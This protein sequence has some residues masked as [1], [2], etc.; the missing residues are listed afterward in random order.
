[1]ID[2]GALKVSTMV[3]PD[4]PPHERAAFVLDRLSSMAGEKLSYSLPAYLASRNA[5]FADYA[6]AYRL[7]RLP[8]ACQSKMSSVA[9]CA[10]SPQQQ[11]G[12]NMLDAKE[13]PREVLDF[14]F[15]LENIACNCRSL[16]TIAA[17]LAN[18]GSC[19]TNNAYVSLSIFMDDPL[20]FHV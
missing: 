3:K 13:D 2:I 20:M 1:M 6:I 12:R 9:Y 4:A 14:Y 5:S 19:P 7:V 18:G 15:Q 8:L 16:A 11:K 17:T 10:L